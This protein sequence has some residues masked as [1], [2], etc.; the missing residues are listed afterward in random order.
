MAAATVD[1]AAL[2]RTLQVTDRH[3][4]EQLTLSRSAPF[5][6]IAKRADG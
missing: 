4:P 3:K 6:L 1:P 5:V 2:L